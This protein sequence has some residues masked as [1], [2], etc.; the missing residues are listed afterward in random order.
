MLVL[1][2][3]LVFNIVFLHFRQN[4]NYNHGGES[5]QSTMETGSGKPRRLNNVEI[6]AGA[7]NFLSTNYEVAYSSY[8]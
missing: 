4:V 5:S 7:T 2:I 8:K 3:I 1:N 6:T